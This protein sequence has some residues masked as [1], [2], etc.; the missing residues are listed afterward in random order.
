M[1][2]ISR[3]FQKA[4][5]EGSSLDQFLTRHAHDVQQQPDSR[6]ALTTLAIL[7]LTHRWSQSRLQATVVGQASDEIAAFLA[8]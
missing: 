3:L 1:T 5:R 8:Q 6:A 2:E 7:D 4:L